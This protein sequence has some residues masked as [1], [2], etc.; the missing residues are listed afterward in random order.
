M[1]LQL[2]GAT[3]FI[4]VTA[5]Y[6]NAVMVTL[7]PH[8]SDFAAKL[9]LPVPHPI[10]A[11][12]IARCAVFPYRAPDGGIAGGGIILKN[13]WSMG[14]QFGYVNGF[15]SP[16]S[17]YG[18]QD[19]D[20]IPDFYG[21]VRMKT[22]E[23]VKL[24]RSA[25]SKLGIPLQEVFAD[26]VPNVT[27]PVTFDTNIVPRY[28]IQ[29]IDP[30]G[31]RVTVEVN[32]D[33]KRVESLQ[34]LSANL[35]RPA[36]KVNVSPPP[37]HGMFDSQIPPP[38]NP[39]YARQLVPVILRA[40]STYGRTLSL[41]VPHILTTNEVAVVR[42][43]N[44]GG[45]PHCE[46]KLTNGWRF[47][48]RHNMVNGYYAPTTLFDN[49]NRSFRL[50]DFEGRWRFNTNQAFELVKSKLEK[51]NYPTNHMHLDFSPH[52]IYAPGG[53]RKIIPRYFLEWYYAPNDE[54]QSKV[55][56]EVNAD[57]GRVESL[58]YDD[59][60]YWNER[61][62]IDVPITLPLTETNATAARSAKQ[63]KPTPNHPPGPFRAM[64]SG[65]R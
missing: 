38:I 63:S 49:Q 52:V 62:P 16:H 25:I 12:D 15:E 19:P 64:P 26:R 50:G 14:F 8:Y 30:R 57:T 21:V 40:I 20:Q 5:A 60:A 39:E 55:E 44:N 11:Q 47:I 27:P 13:G 54:M 33:S 58:Y 46:I 3:Q 42:V 1:I 48:F 23:A 9:E 59:L 4:K 7:L 34:M 2:G 17:Y 37:G 28:L 22:N 53:F 56:A 18:L 31:G 35:M 32:A 41:P 45:W 43:E 10:T 36:P 51:L 65:G 61:P 24:A 29:W 6:S